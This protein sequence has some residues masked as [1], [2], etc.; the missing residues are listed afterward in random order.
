MN[1]RNRKE[2]GMNAPGPEK[3]SHTYSKNIQL[4]E[5]IP[6]GLPELGHNNWQYFFNEDSGDF[7]KFTISSQLVVDFLSISFDVVPP[8]NQDLFRS[9]INFNAKS[10]KNRKQNI[11]TL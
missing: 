5:Y 9:L 4:N 2:G 10:S 6:L 8:I 1:R 3:K 7:G 11:C